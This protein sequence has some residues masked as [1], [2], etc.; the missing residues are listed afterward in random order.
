MANYDKIPNIEIENAKLVF[1]PNF[2][3]AAEKFNRQGN[4]NFDI[5]LE[6]EELIKQLEKDGWNVK[7]WTSKTDPD[8]EEIKFLNVAFNYDNFPPNIF[9]ISGKTK[10]RLDAETVDV[11][12]GSVFS[13]IDLVIRP[14]VW[15]TE[16]GSGVKAYLKTGYFVLEHDSFMDKYST[17]ALEEELPF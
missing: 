6:D 8:A 13:H 5:L 12:Q 4:R 11:L 14:Y 15:S 9:L 1:K 3:G 16:S 7:T 10:T 2:I 17:E